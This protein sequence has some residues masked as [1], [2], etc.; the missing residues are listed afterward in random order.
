M[1]FNHNITNFLFKRQLLRVMAHPFH[2][3]TNQEVKGKFIQLPYTSRTPG[4]WNPIWHEFSANALLSIS[5]ESIVYLHMHSVSA[6]YLKNSI[7]FSK[8]I[9][10]K[11]NWWKKLSHVRICVI[12]TE[13]IISVLKLLNHQ[14]S[15]FQ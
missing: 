12:F 14:I 3:Q 13:S 7:F 6:K 11:M 2:F 1:A 15:L 4:Y 10:F 8:N 9:K 5:K